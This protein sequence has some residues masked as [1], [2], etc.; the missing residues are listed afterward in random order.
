MSLAFL[1]LLV[2]VLLIARQ[3]AKANPG[4]KAS[5]K[6]ALI[7]IVVS[8]GV[9][10]LSF[11]LCGYSKG[12]STLLHVGQTIFGPALTALL[13]FVILLVVRSGQDKS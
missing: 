6:P 1:L 13:V 4:Q 7:G 5:M 10:I 9:L 11:G 8:I 12:N 3:R 2:S